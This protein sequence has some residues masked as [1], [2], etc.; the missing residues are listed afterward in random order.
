MPSRRAWLVWSLLMLQTAHLA[1]Q[2]ADDLAEPDA[3]P[4]AHWSEAKARPFLAGIVDVGGLV[5]G[6]LMVGYGKPH[7]MWAGVEAEAVSTS[8]LGLSSVRARIALLIADLAVAYRR[9]WAYRRG[10]LTREDSYSD[11]DLLG[12]P[13]AAYHSLDTWLWGII[14]VGDGYFDWELEAIRVYGVPRGLDVY[15]EWLRVPAR[16]PWLV[17]TRLGYAHTFLRGRLALGAL[18]EWIKPG[19]R[20]SWYRAGPLASY[21]FSSHWDLSGLLTLEVQSPDQLGWFNGV[22]GTLRARYRFAT[23]EKR[24][25]TAVVR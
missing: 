14:P 13:K 5:R 9:T 12:E 3:L 7:W 11:A 25:A 21:A 16:P 6:K 2:S 8:E 18:G 15:E 4:S 20:G 24:H 17:A 10:W 19:E 23:G 1:A 22:W